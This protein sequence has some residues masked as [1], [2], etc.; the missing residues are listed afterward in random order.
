MKVK[1]G[2]RSNADIF[3]HPC[4]VEWSLGDLSKVIIGLLC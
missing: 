4:N 1:K 3:V 2:V